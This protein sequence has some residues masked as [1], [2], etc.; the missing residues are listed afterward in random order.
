MPP[1][2]PTF[3]VAQ[4]PDPD[5]TLPYLLRLPID[6]GIELKAKERW[7]A[8]ARVYCH[9]VDEWPAD[10][11]VLEEVAIR[12]CARRGRAIDLTLERGRNNR[13]QF[14]FTEPHPG[15]AGGRTMI[16]WQTARTARR[17]R[18]GQRAP[19]RRASGPGTLTIEVDTRERYPY[20]FADRAVE[21]E[22][23]SLTCGDYAV[24]VDD[25][26]LA[27]VERKTLEDL[28]H[29]FVDGSLGY[30]MAD[31]S[32]LPAAVVVVEARYSQLLSAPRVQPGWLAELTARMHVRYPS[33]PIM[34]CDSRKLAED[35]T[36]RFLAAALAE[37]RPADDDS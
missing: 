12:H 24:R 15:R 34:F 10:A 5:S 25:R 17:A 27:A 18:P 2:E 26:L 31:L 19:T 28:I 8:T 7:P 29:S 22:R 9:P 1:D 11:P 30:A 36:H 23:R 32:A 14:V 3:V 20:R 4:N 35:F 37:H 6:G 16:F 13:S 21:R 33:V